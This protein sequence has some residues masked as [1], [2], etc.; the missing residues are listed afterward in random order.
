MLLLKRK[1]FELSSGSPLVKADEA[2][3]VARTEE[4]VAAAEAEAVRIAADAKAAAEEE[5]KRGY[6]DG[7]AAGREE[8]LL[9]KMNLLDESVAYMERI[10]EEIANVVIRAM[11][12]CV[13]EIGDRELVVQTVRKSLQT[14]IRNQSQITVKV[15][16]DM[17]A[18]VKERL[19]SVLADF[20]TVLHADIREDPHLK[21]A[22]CIV[23]TE[24]GSVESSIEKQLETIEKSIRKSIAR[25][26]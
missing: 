11:K 26:G 10:E 1:T 6:A 16:P 12:K 2:A 9:Q 3:T 22:A 20:P 19:D 18:A 14:I 25:K 17:V 24:V 5:R 21:G 4:I 15:A 13:C 23:E 7:I 8:I